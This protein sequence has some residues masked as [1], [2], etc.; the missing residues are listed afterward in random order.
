ML[1]L[2]ISTAST[3][4]VYRNCDGASSNGK[5]SRII[6]SYKIIFFLPIKHN[7]KKMIITSHESYDNFI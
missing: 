3:S 4:F 2:H 6:M 5:A 7:N 1:K